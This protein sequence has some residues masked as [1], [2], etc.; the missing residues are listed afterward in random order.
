MLPPLY[1]FSLC[2]MFPFVLHEPHFLQTG[3]VHFLYLN[4]S[5]Q[6]S[7]ALVNL[8]ILGVSSHLHLYFWVPAFFAPQSFFLSHFL[9]LSS[10]YLLF[11]YSSPFPARPVQLRQCQLLLA[12]LVARRQ[13]EFWLKALLAYSCIMNITYNRNVLQ[14][15]LDKETPFGSHKYTFTC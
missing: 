10:S 3:P 9:Q 2:C 15:A 12:F 5:L 7:R 6:K 14:F 1:R 13:V 8:L 11:I 4:F